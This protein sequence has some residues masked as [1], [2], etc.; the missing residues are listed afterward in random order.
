MAE[1]SNDRLQLTLFKLH[2]LLDFTQMMGE[3][4]DEMR[5]MQRFS[6]LLSDDLGINRI[7]LF[8]REGDEWKLL[9]NVGCDPAW[10]NRIDVAR[11]LSGYD[12]TLVIRSQARDVMPEIDVVIPLAGPEETV[13]GYVL[14]GDTREDLIGVSPV[15]KH[16]PFAQTL[17]MIAF[18]ALQNYMFLK[19]ELWER[20]LRQ[21]LQLATQLQN[22]LLLRG[23]PL[24]K[25]KDIELATEYMPHYEVGGDFYDVQDL[26]QGKL[27][28]CIADV[29]GKGISA[30]MMTTSFQANYRAHMSSDVSLCDLVQSLNARLYALLQGEKF[31]TLF[32]A[33]YDTATRRLEYINAGHNPPYLY[34]RRTG[35][36]QWFTASTVGVGMVDELPQAHR[37]ELVVGD[38]SVLFCY[39]DGLVERRD[40]E[41]RERYSTE[42]IETAVREHGT[43]Q[44]IVSYAK[45]RVESERDSGVARPFDDVTMVV[46]HFKA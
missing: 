44:A 15:I 12:R 9:W 17:S 33:R 1:R 23:S 4:R 20:E 14:L 30:A 40:S 13:S 25:L 41:N 46:L 36:A 21:E 8:V 3:E 18:V 31:I 35:E 6:R 34:N 29:S 37:Q 38:E 24:P 42:I 16:L 7:L 39:T 32:V 5:L 27:G 45:E 10:A 43:A 2:T 19:R 22:I 28:I 11:D 26:G